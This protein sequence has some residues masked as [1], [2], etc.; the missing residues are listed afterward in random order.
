[1]SAVGDEEIFLPR[2]SPGGPPRNGNGGSIMRLLGLATV[3]LGLVVSIFSAGYN[4]RSVTVIEQ[5]QE[6]FVRK[7][8]QQ[9]QLQNVIDR[10]TDMSKQLDSLRVEV[11]ALRR[12]P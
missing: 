7:D 2:L 10:L 3:I 11:D 1:M 8:V 4:W 9:Q 6:N 12:K 5:N